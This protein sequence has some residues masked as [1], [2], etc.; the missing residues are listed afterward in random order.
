[1]MAHTQETVRAIVEKQRA[2]FKTGATLD[3]K[4]QAA[5]VFQNR[6]DA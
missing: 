1:M 4:R 2:Y 3:V 6:R 5:G